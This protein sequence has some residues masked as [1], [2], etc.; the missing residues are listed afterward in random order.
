MLFACHTSAYR[1][2]AVR[3][4]GGMLL[5]AALPGAPSAQHFEK[6]RSLYF[7]RPFGAPDRCR[8]SA[9]LPLP[10]QISALRR[11][12][13]LPRHPVRF[14]RHPPGPVAARHVALPYFPG[15]PIME[16]A[17]TPFYLRLLPHHLKYMMAGE[18]RIR[19]DERWS[20]NIGRSA[21]SGAALAI[22]SQRHERR[23]ASFPNAK[24]SPWV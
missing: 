13:Y 20:R 7:I 6:R 15:T 1:K 21:R 10:A 16:C 3:L 24:R 12:L 17:P 8:K 22:H 2:V 11:D 4:P 5:L 18:A 23:L 14:R 19:A 9:R